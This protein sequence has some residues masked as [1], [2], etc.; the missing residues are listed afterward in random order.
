MKPAN[1]PAIRVEVTPGST[2]RYSGGGFTV[3][4]ELMIEVTGK[5]FPELM[6]ESCAPKPLGMTQSTYEQPLPS[7]NW[8]SSPATGY[9]G[10]SKAP[11]K[12]KWHVYPEM[13]AA[14]LWDDAVRP[15]A[16]RGWHSGNHGGEIA[17]GDFLN[18]RFGRCLLCRKAAAAWVWLWRGTERRCGFLTAAEMKVLTPS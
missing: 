16:V 14:G 2:W 10:N 6:R 15:G 5:A 11:V 17:P 4:Q 8:P 18:P 12:N 3:M 13:A 1:T 7:R 9:Y